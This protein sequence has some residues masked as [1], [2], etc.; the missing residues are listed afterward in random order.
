MDLRQYV[1]FET[2]NDVRI[3]VA[4]EVTCLSMSLSMVYCTAFF[5]VMAYNGDDP[6]G[7]MF[8]EFFA[9]GERYMPATHRSE[10][11]GGYGVQVKHLMRN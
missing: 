2:I 11:C 4:M 6:S 9:P 3:S 5:T 1:I 8:V 7:I 10:I